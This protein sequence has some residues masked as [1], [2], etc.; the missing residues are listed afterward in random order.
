MRNAP[1]KNAGTGPRKG[2][3]EP[4]PGSEAGQTYARAACAF[5]DKKFYHRAIMR[6]DDGRVFADRLQIRF[7]NL[8]VPGTVEKNLQKAACWCTFVSGSDKPKVLS[9]LAANKEW[10]EEFDMAMNACRE[11][12][13]EERAWAYHL[14]M[15][16]AEA[17]YNN[18]IMLAKEE[19]REEKAI[20][21]AR[22]LKDS[23]VDIEL[24]A[25]ATGLSVEEIEKL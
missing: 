7:F 3:G 2:G 22:I 17:D 15:D 12:S 1:V 9:E 20:E 18:G 25:K 11:I 6:L 23:A 16:R 24:I 21:T 14:S 19:G 4:K 13:E 5:E 10:K 8:A